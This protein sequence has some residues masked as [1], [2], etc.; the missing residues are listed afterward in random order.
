M[1]TAKTL[2]SIEYDKIL[3]SVANFAVLNKTKDRIIDFNPVSDLSEAEFLLNKTLEAYKLLYT[4]SV[5]GIF[6][7]DDVTEYLERVDRGGTLNNGELLKVASNLKSA[8][9]LKNS[10]SSVNY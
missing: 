6:Y 8:R 7:V 5:G 10:F 9:M 3:S 2:K 4:Y 1:I